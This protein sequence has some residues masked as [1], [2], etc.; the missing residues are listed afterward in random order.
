M[1]YLV[2]TPIDVTQD[3]LTFLAAGGV[4]VVRGLFCRTW[5]LAVHPV[6][7]REE[8]TVI[9]LSHGAGFVYL[10]PILSSWLAFKLGEKLPIVRCHYGWYDADMLHLSMNASQDDSGGFGKVEGKV[11]ETKLESI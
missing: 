7:R 8:P 3:P 2:E 11:G 1:W 6:I 5:M 4:L 10:A 9:I